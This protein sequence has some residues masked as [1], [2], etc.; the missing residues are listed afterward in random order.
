M[1]SRGAFSQG[2]TGFSGSD[3]RVFI[4][5]ACYDLLTVD[6]TM[7]AKTE[8]PQEEHVLYCE[9]FQG[10]SFDF[11]GKS[12]FTRFDC[13]EFVNCTLLIDHGTE[14][15]SF[16]ECVFKDCN[17]DNLEAAA[18]RGLYLKDNFFDRPL[19]V[20]RAEFENKLAK[21]LAEQKAKGK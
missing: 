6:F 14:Q 4:V 1:A 5:R 13:C 10:R 18:W 21:V 15:L 20:R 8:G 19:A 2:S 7:K 16:T 12:V 17:I 11:Q 9:R 3:Y